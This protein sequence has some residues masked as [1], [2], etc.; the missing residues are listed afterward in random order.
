MHAI[1]RSR[2]LLVLAI[3]IV[4]FAPVIALRAQV[5]M[6]ACRN[7]GNVVTI[8]WPD[9]APPVYTNVGASRAES[10]VWLGGRR[11]ARVT[12][13]LGTDTLVYPDG[14][15]VPP[16]MYDTNARVLVTGRRRVQP[17]AIKCD[18][19]GNGIDVTS[20]TLTR[21]SMSS[22]TGASIT[23]TTGYIRLTWVNVAR[24]RVAACYP[25][26]L[27]SGSTRSRYCPTP[28]KPPTVAEILQYTDT[29]KLPPRI[30]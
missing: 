11:V 24:V 19:N 16:A 5:P 4:L 12:T 23:P 29:T 17:N 22:A 27:V 9:T 30:P 21:W 7:I 6:S 2:W 28:A 26:P 14:P 18:G 13:A 25:A 15:M 10:I 3:L 8:V 20:N 1:L